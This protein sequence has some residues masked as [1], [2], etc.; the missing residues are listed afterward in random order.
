MIDPHEEV[1]L[2]EP[3]DDTSAKYQSPTSNLQT[4]VSHNEGNGIEVDSLHQSLRL[5][6]NVQNRH[7]VTPL[8]QLAAAWASSVQNDILKLSQTQIE[9]DSTCEELRKQLSL[10][11]EDLAGLRAVEA[12]QI[13]YKPVVAFT[14]IAGQALIAI[15]I[16]QVRSISY[17][18]GSALLLIGIFL[19]IPTYFALF[20][21]R[22]KNV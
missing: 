16:D 18:L 15:G 21:K 22:S 9:R 4:L 19:L 14:L 11:R 3:S 12:E 5:L 20:Y 13:K 7:G 8:L 1:P 17:G 2:P 10:A 6:S